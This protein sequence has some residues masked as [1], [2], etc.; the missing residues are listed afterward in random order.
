MAK[1]HHFYEAEEIVR[2]VDALATLNQREGRL[3]TSRSALIGNEVRKLI[4]LNAPRLRKA[5]IQIPYSVFVNPAAPH[6]LGGRK[7]RLLVRKRKDL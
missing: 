7:H 2:V 6:A 5:G 4:R 3:Y 1:S